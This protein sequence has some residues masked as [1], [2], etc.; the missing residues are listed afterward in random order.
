M[1]LLDRII[2]KAEGQEIAELKKI[3]K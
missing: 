2:E 1:Q 3:K